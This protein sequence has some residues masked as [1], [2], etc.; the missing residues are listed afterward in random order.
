MIETHELNVVVERVLGDARV[1]V[2]T[3]SESNGVRRGIEVLKVER[4]RIEDNVPF[5]LLC[6]SE[7]FLDRDLGGGFARRG[8]RALFHI[9]QLS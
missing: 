4:D 3:V 7:G 1:V 8:W 2:L 5:R 6:C 9:S